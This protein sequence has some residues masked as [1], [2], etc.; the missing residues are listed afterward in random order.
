MS[1]EE[2]STKICTRNAFNKMITIL[3]MDNDNLKKRNK[4]EKIV[5][6][7]NCIF[8]STF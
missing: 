2:F 6:K 5:D 8:I 7:R 4:K 1:K 3:E